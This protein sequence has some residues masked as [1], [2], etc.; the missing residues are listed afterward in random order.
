MEIHRPHKS[1]KT[2]ERTINVRSD[3]SL[4]NP[5]L[6]AIS[7]SSLSERRLVGALNVYQNDDGAYEIGIDGPFPSRGCAGAV[8]LAGGRT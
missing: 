1:L 6:G 5:S 2:L 4:Q 8:A 3:K 7:F